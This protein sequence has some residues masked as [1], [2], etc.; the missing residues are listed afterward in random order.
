M[1]MNIDSLDEVTCALLNYNYLADFH[2]KLSHALSL[3]RSIIATSR[4]LFPGWVPGDKEDEIKPKDGIT[5]LREMLEDIIDMIDELYEPI[6]AFGIMTDKE[7][8]QL[9]HK[10]NRAM[11]LAHIIED[12][13]LT[14]REYKHEDWLENYIYDLA[15]VLH[16]AFDKFHKF[17]EIK[18]RMDNLEEHNEPPGTINI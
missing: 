5:P 2:N 8:Q 3:A 16:D 18:M 12:I 13:I 6:A 17:G 1:N 10:V 9:Y 15:E 7:S 4:S 11:E 14:G